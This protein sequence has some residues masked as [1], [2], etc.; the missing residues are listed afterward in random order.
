MLAAHT[1]T[2]RVS[3]AKCKKNGV[4]LTMSIQYGC[5]ESIRCISVGKFRFLLTDFLWC[6]RF[7][8][9]PSHCGAPSSAITAAPPT[10][11]PAIAPPERDDLELDAAEFEEA[12]PAKNTEAPRIVFLCKMVSHSVEACYQIPL[13]ML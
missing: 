9:P 4:Q 7:L 5:S 10:A 6:I 3:E 2:V 13:G 12:D 1:D 11:I 8:R